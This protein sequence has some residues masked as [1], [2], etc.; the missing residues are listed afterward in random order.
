MPLVAGLGALSSPFPGWLCHLTG[1]GRLAGVS[2]GQ[3]PQR[4]YGRVTAAPPGRRSC[5]RTLWASAIYTIFSVWIPYV[6]QEV[7]RVEWDAIRGHESLRLVGREP[8]HSCR[9]GTLADGEWSGHAPT[10]AA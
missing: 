7:S 2:L 5:G 9:C 8:A 1:R 4:H 6:D 10:S 3:C